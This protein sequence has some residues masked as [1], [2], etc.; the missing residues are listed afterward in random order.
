MEEIIQEC[1]NL[2]KYTRGHLPSLLRDKS[3]EAMRDFSWDTILTEAKERSGAMR[4]PPIGTIY[5]LL[6]HQFNR[7]LNLVQRIN[8][9]LLANGQAETKVCFQL[10]KMQVLGFPKGLM[11]GE[12]I[13]SPTRYLEENGFHFPPQ[14]ITSEM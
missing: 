5:S 4:I 7:E 14:T 2:A 3:F 12:V 10:N 11:E 6:L 8:T 13:L 1:E 9:V